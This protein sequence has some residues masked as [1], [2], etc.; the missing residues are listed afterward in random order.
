MFEL[1]SIM[2]FCVLG[3]AL[4][5]RVDHA[6][7][8]RWFFVAY[9]RGQPRRVQVTSP[10]GENIAR[11]RFAALPIAVLILSLAG[12]EAAPGRALVLVLAATWNLSPHA[13]SY[14]RSAT[15]MPPPS[16][17]TGSRRSTT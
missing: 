11:I 10:L 8:I 4:T 15:S 12:L 3:G 7:T 5:W 16:R 13:W 17:S 9:A 2:T 14:P 1:V 6:R